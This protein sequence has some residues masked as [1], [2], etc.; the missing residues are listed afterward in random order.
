MANP[1]DAT[2]P[3]LAELTRASSFIFCGT[4][5]EAGASNVHGLEPAAN[6][7]LVR[8]GVPLRSD[9]ALG[10]TTGRLVTVATDAPDQLPPGTEAVFFTAGWIH[11]AEI[12]VRELAHASRDLTDTVR[13]EV[14]RLP[15]LHLMDRL[16]QARLVV[17]AEVESTGRLRRPRERRAP[18]WARAQL[19]VVTSLKGRAREPILYFPTSD[20]HHWFR[21]KRPRRGQRRVFLLHA[22]DEHAERWLQDDEQGVV[23]TALDP[24]DIQLETQLDHIR[25]LLREARS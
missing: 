15:D 12:A 23:F 10:D 7:L 9:P 20:S 16:A 6:L 21:A 13:A 1:A 8:V 22:E 17:L 18:R 25:A 4:V 14:G 5:E 11:G 2:G 24:A 3:P 19:R